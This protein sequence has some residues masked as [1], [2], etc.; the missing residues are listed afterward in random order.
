MSKDPI[1]L[2]RW[3]VSTNKSI[4][5][6]EDDKFLDLVDKIIEC[7]GDA[8]TN[9]EKTQINYLQELVDYVAVLRAAD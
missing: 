3:I 4:N 8:K 5:E 6:L 2:A 9:P 1:E 7:L